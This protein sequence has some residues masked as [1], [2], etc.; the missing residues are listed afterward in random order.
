MDRE[1]YFC[2]NYYRKPERES[3]WSRLQ[4]LVRT[5]IKKLTS[6]P[7]EDV[8]TISEYNWP[9]FSRPGFVETPRDEDFVCDFQCSTLCCHCQAVVN[10]IAEV[11]RRHLELEAARGGWILCTSEGFDHLDSETALEK[12]ADAGC[13]LCVRF[14]ES[15]RGQVGGGGESGL[16]HNP[17][18]YAVLT[19]Y[20]EYHAKKQ[21]SWSI[22]LKLPSDSPVYPGDTKTHVWRKVSISV[23][24]DAGGFP[25]LQ[26]LTLTEHNLHNNGNCR[27]SSTC[28]KLRQ[29]YGSL[30]PHKIQESHYKSPKSGSR[31]VKNVTRNAIQTARSTQLDCST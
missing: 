21:E 13:A 22:F 8:D 17:E 29:V 14:T 5:P 10:G 16:P 20:S 28:T 7:Q 12:S 18:C 15:L 6:R 19:Y 2:G 11:K 23:F 31:S 30:F 1:A 3:V 26:S 9:R 27:T 24:T 4:R 25:W